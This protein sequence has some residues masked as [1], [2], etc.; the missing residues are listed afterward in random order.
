MPIDFIGR[1]TAASELKASLDVS[2]Q[3]GRTIADRVARASMQQQGFSLPSSDGKSGSTQAGQEAPI[4]IETEMV[5]LADEQLRYA[6]TAKLL[7]KTY[8]GLHES[9]QSK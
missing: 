4:D 6:T 5:N 1:T 8:A 2:A 7:Q 3:R 9:L